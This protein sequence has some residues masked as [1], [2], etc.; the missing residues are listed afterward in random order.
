MYHDTSRDHFTAQHYKPPLLWESF[1]LDSGTW[2]WECVFIQ[3]QMHKS[4]ALDVGLAHSQHFNFSQ[5]CS[6]AL[7]SGICAVLPH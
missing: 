2:M 4:R 5:R 3:P 1:L 6:L 7:R